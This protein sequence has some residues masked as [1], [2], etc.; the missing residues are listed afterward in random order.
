MRMSALT[1]VASPARKYPP[2]HQE[3]PTE[4]TKKNQPHRRW[5][6]ADKLTDG[7]R[8]DDQIC[9]IA[10]RFAEGVSATLI[11]S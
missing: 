3:Q 5:L 4:G 7:E 1:I 10:K 11:Q 6:F 2:H 9:E 8:A